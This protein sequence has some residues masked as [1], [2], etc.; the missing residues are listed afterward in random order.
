MNRLIVSFYVF[1]SI[2]IIACQ[3]EETEIVDFSENT[4]IPKNSQLA[5]L[6]KNIVI[7]DG[8]YDD[9]VDKG[10]CFSI[11][12][13]YFILLNGRKI[14]IENIRDYDD[15]SGLDIIEIQFPV[16][17]S[18]FNHQK[19]TILNQEALNA[20]TKTCN[21]VDDD[22]EC[23]D[24]IYPIQF[25]TFNSNTNQFKIVDAEHDAM[26][27]KFMSGLNENTLVSLNYPINVM[28]Y[29]GKKMRIWHN[30]DLLISITDVATDCDENDN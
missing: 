14:K 7:H 27:F 19:E 13:P 15:L 22:I 23:I 29:N 8:S 16:T 12:F 5:S 2:F 28:F 11:D 21:L 26:L 18:L 1:I 6:M 24:F 30:E 17:I 9:I 3:K 20:F 10:N 25:S 4:E